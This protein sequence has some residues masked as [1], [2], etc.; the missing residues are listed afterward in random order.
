MYST[1]P[2]MPLPA[3]PRHHHKR[4][5][6]EWPG[7]SS[8]LLPPREPEGCAGVEGS[9][10][11]P[12]TRPI[13]ETPATKMERRTLVVLL[14]WWQWQRH[15]CCFRKFGNL[16]EFGRNML[17]RLDSTR[18]CEAIAGFV[19]AFLRAWQHHCFPCCPPIVKD[20]F[21]PF[22]VD[23]RV[24]GDQKDVAAVVVAGGGLLFRCSNP[25]RPNR[26]KYSS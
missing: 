21:D 6:L 25:G 16:C 2:T 12:A 5:L 19:A 13:C 15:W 22:V 3:I 9:S 8:P 11:P 4:A 10:K 23:A 17:R 14:L 26:G 7:P 1:K 20:G 24:R 18:G